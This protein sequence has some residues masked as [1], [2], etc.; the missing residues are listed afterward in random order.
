MTESIVNIDADALDEEWTRQPSLVEATGRQ[1]AMAKKKLA[2]A[3]DNLEVVESEVANKIR[4]RPEK[5]VPGG[6]S[7]EGAIRE[8]LPLQQEVKDA[9]ELLRK[10]QYKVDLLQNLMSALENKKKALESLVYLHGASYFGKPRLDKNMEE[11]ARRNFELRR[12]KKRLQRGSLKR[13]S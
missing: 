4:K 3:K 13:K 5:Y 7:T 6:K 10:R 9:K 11:D 12:K 8:T 1:S 2:E